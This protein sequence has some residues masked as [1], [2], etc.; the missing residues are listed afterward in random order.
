MLYLRP[1]QDAKYCNKDNIQKPQ[2]PQFSLNILCTLKP[3][4]K[5]LYRTIVE[6]YFRR[7]SRRVVGA[8]F[9]VPPSTTFEK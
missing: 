4:L 5:R 9:V 7:K 3:D 6:L 8:L 1:L 2:V